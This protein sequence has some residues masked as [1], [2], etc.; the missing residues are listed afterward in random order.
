MLKSLGLPIVL[1]M[2]IFGEIC[3][4]HI[5]ASASERALD[6][7]IDVCFSEGNC[8]T[9]S[10]GLVMDYIYFCDDQTTCYEV[11]S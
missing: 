11:L 4:L 7:T 9:E 3:Y 2:L 5:S 8:Q 6:F 1:L 10:V